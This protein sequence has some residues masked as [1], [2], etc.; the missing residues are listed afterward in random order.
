M[1]WWVLIAVSACILGGVAVV[2]RSQALG[3]AAVMAFTVV[4]MLT[5]D[6][7]MEAFWLVAASALAI[8]AVV[9]IRTCCSAMRL[10]DE[11]PAEASQ[12]VG[13]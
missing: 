10:P 9:L 12:R 7:R 5:V 2:V 1:A 3:L 13:D 11:P 4:G 6:S 8:E